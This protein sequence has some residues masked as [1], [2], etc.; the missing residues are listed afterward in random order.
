MISIEQSAYAQSPAAAGLDLSSEV[1]VSTPLQ[2]L[3]FYFGT[4]AALEAEGFIPPGTE[5]PAGF[6]TVEWQSGGLSFGISR[7]RP[8]GV[9]GPRKVLLQLD[10]WELRVDLVEKPN[11]LARDV[12]QKTKA[13]NDAIHANSV[14][15]RAEA[16]LW[17]QRL[18]AA[19]A[20]DAYQAFKAQIPGL[21]K[22]RRAARA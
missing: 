10:W 17:S 21:V 9:K 8:E 4:R 14:A 22:S 7:A 16:R 6:S 20:D 12:V 13:L 11:L 5:W 19:M 2:C 1:I 18:S 3:A 15:G